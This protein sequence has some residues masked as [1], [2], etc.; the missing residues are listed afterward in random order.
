[1][2]IRPLEAHL[3]DSDRQKDGRTDERTW[4]C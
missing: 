1:M 3:F 2:K 4:R